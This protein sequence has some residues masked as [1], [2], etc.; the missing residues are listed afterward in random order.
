M[1]FGPG[2]DRDAQVLAGFPAAATEHVLS[3]EAEKRRHS[4]VVAGGLDA[5]HGADRAD[6]VVAGQ[7]VDECIAAM[8]AT[9][10]DRLIVLATRPWRPFCRRLRPG[11][12][13]VLAPHVRIPRVAP[14][15]V[16]PE[17]RRVR[18]Q[19]P[20]GHLPAMSRSEVGPAVRVAGGRRGLGEA[21]PVAADSHS[22]GCWAGDDVED[23]CGC[24]TS[25]SAGG[26]RC[27]RSPF[28][29]VQ[30]HRV[31]G[32]NSCRKAEF[33][34]GSFGVD[35]VGCPPRVARV[36]AEESSSAALRGRS[37]YVFADMDDPKP[38]R[39]QCSF[40]T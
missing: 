14:L 1:R 34:R 17:G 30:E 37:R 24:H 11:G 25:R 12:I 35:S 40:A 36:A 23:R 6:H 38:R 32:D 3:Q 10:V 8:V 5:T 2:S 7:S 13:P 15:T 39:V 21:I 16:N 9:P 33:A 20:T 18:R 31:N 4:G 22:R 19:R 29:G 27:F 28:S 26:A